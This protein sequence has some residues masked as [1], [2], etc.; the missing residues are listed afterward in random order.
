MR[1]TERTIY[2]IH[3]H[4]T[5][6]PQ[7]KCVRKR[8][9]AGVGAFKIILR[10]VLCWCVSYKNHQPWKAAAASS[11]HFLFIVFWLAL[12]LTCRGGLY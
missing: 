11:N 7:I 5:N 6:H 3:S 4:H 9:G 10:T 2:F 12:L 8:I 1:N